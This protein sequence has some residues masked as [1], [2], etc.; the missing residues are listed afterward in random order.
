MH[1]SAIILVL[2]LFIS[3]LIGQCLF[4]SDKEALEINNKGNPSANDTCMS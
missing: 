3:I 4:K 1:S 2:N